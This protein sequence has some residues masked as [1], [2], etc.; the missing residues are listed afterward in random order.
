MTVRNFDVYRNIPDILFD[1]NSLKQNKNRNENNSNDK[2]SLKRATQF[3]IF[4]THALI[5]CII[6]F[7]KLSFLIE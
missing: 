4:T 1:S 7:F 2:H 6:L 5:L 3:F